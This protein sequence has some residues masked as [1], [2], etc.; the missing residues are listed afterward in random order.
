MK[1]E[2]N[3]DDL[4]STPFPS[5][6]GVGQKTS[7]WLDNI[8]SL[9]RWPFI[10][11]LVMVFLSITIV[12]SIVWLIWVSLAKLLGIKIECLRKIKYFPN[13]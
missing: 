12:S 6:V 8:P 10:F 1:Q 5:R 9:I 13:W 7:K 4:S 11:C 3:W 2:L